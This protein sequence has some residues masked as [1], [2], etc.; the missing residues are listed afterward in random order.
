LPTDPYHPLIRDR[1]ILVETFDQLT[2]VIGFYENA[3]WN[4]DALEADL[5]RVHLR[6]IQKQQ[7]IEK[8]DLD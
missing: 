4:T 8:R 7:E 6:L 5:R 2:Q 1:K 3:G